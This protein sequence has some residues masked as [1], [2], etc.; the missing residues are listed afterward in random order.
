MSFER[1]SAEQ[2]YFIFGRHW[3]PCEDI[4]PIGLGAC[5]LCFLKVL[6]R[7]TYRVLRRQYYLSDSRSTSQVLLFQRS[8]LRFVS[9]EL[10]DPKALSSVELDFAASI[11]QFIDEIGS[12][13]LTIR[14]RHIEKQKCKFPMG[15][16]APTPELQRR[17]APKVNFANCGKLAEISC[18]IFYHFAMQYMDGWKEF[19][20]VSINTMKP[21][22]CYGDH[23]VSGIHVGSMD[24]LRLN[25]TGNP[26][27]HFGQ[28]KTFIFDAW[29]EECFSFLTL[30][31]FFQAVKN[32][33]LQDGVYIKK[34]SKFQTR[35]V[36]SGFL[37]NWPH[38]LPQS[39]LPD[40]DRGLMTFFQNP[41]TGAIL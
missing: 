8:F 28:P 27:P 39:L 9:N 19:H 38:D 3:V 22:E 13:Y 34:E 30:G 40:I 14:M 4:L 26:Q 11:A 31:E 10:G 6:C 35:V 29:G 17:S 32:E 18:I 12:A 24:E 33:C 23:V 21:K 20:I 37:A 7:E 36:D 5:Y 25:V 15:H 2:T 16:L 1:A 41:P